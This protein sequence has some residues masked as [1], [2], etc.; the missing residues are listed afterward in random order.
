[1]GAEEWGAVPLLGDEERE[2]DEEEDQADDDFDTEM[3][4]FDVSLAFT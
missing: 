2:E 3:E 1:M 4:N